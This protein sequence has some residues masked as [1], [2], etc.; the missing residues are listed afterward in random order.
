M[1]VTFTFASPFEGRV[2]AQGNPQV[3]FELGSRDIELLLRIP[4]DSSCGTRLQGDGQFVNNVVIQQH[5]II[6]QDSDKTIRVECSFDAGDQT[7]SFAPGDPG[8][9]GGGGI[10]IS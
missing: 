8:R 4:L 6:M 1:A 5:P 3:C 7:V 10:D 2:Y 9:T